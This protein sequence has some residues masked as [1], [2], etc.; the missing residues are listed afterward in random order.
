MRQLECGDLL[1]QVPLCDKTDFEKFFTSTKHAQKIEVKCFGLACID[2][3][4][5]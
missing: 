4:S 2:R 5:S 3:R 1:Q